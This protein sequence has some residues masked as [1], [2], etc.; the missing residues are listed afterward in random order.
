[1]AGLAIWSS[2]DGKT[3]KT[4]DPKMAKLVYTNEDM[5]QLYNYVKDN[6]LYL[7]YKSPKRPLFVKLFCEKDKNGN[8]K[9]IT[10]NEVSLPQANNNTRNC[11][12][13]SS[14][15]KFIAGLS[16]YL[17]T[18]NF[19]LDTVLYVK[20][21]SRNDYLIKAEKQLS[22][23]KDK[24]SIDQQED[25]NEQLKKDLAA[26]TGENMSKDIY[27]AAMKENYMIKRIKEFFENQKHLTED[28]ALHIDE[29]VSPAS[30]SEWEG[31]DASKIIRAAQ[32]G[33]RTAREYI[34]YKMEGAIA[35]TMWHN[36]LG[37]NKDAAYRRLR[38]GAKEEWL[39]IAWQVLT[40]GFSASL[41]A[42]GTERSEI[43]TLDQ[44]DLSKVK[45]DNIWSAF[46][47]IYTQKLGL[48]AKDFNEAN[49]RSGISGT[50]DNNITTSDYAKYSNVDNDDES[51]YSGV[52]DEGFEGGYENP[53]SYALHNAAH[54]EFM[55]KWKEF[56]QDEELNT[57]K[58]GVSPANVLSAVLSNP[59][60]TNMKNLADDIGLARM[61]FKVYLEKAIEIMTSY[62]GI[63]PQELFSELKSN[64][65]SKI[66]SYLDA[67]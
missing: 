25:K 61:T 3:Y 53:E 10:S 36:F 63:E 19:K 65:S 30:I 64:D 23:N 16:K 47:V 44:F 27:Q 41:T 46:T 39:S 62:Y 45:T 34:F 58:K 43:S 20:D 50:G 9:A 59:E 28:F 33:S 22:Q 1:M 13:E 11:K 15:L 60:E 2:D 49:A 67:A 12:I 21:V 4:I 35:K 32:K 8:F 56:V 51:N 14:R 66:A 42:Y 6:A 7:Y 29:I 17:G 31:E 37:S 26:K 48:A 40:G 5:G 54:S 52:S 18:A 24:L 38:D 57:K 55:N